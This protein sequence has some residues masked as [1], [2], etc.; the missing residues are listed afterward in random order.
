[1]T[2]RYARNNIEVLEIWYW[3]KRELIQI[4]VDE[5]P[6]DYW[7][8]GHF[9]NGDQI[10]D[11]LRVAFRCNPEASTRIGN[12]F[13]ADAETLAAGLIR[14]KSHEQAPEPGAD[15]VLERSA[16]VPHPK[17]LS[18]SCDYF[19]EAWYLA[20]NPDVAD[21]IQRGFLNSAA[22]HFIWFGCHEGR[23]PR[24]IIVDEQYYLEVYD[25]VR[26]AIQAGEIRSAQHHFEARGYWEGR[27][28]APS[29]E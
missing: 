6:K 19:D 12:P 17:P 8:Y 22:E 15:S 29:P 27:K 13:L 23:M 2:E 18:V 3:Y 9:D 25:D 28:S 4:G 10:P 5:V 20:T 24:E 1:M 16:P 7:A 21:A 11:D 26:K 14:E